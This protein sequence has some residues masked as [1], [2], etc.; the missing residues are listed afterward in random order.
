MKKAVIF[1]IALAITLT[2][3]AQTQQVSMY[4]VNDPDGWTNLRNEPG[5]D[6]DV[7]HRIPNKT[8]VVLDHKKPV[9]NNWIPVIY[10]QYYESFYIDQRRL[11]PIEEPYVS[12]LKEFS[13]FAYGPELVVNMISFNIPNLFATHH[14]AVDNPDCVS[15]I[16]DLKNDKVILEFDGMGCAWIIRSDTLSFY[17]FDYPFSGSYTAGSTYLNPILAIYKLYQKNGEYDFYTEIYPEPRTVSKEEAE[18]IVKNITDILDKNPSYFYTYPNFHEFCRQLFLAYC[19][20]VDKAKEIVENLKIITESY[21]D[22]YIDVRW[23][24]DAYDRTKL[25]P[26]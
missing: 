21:S 9:I 2:A 19:S 8:I 5:T 11:I 14:P 4:V 3:F 10:P 12:K 24:F 1:S 15:I 20:G 18:K 25:K 7:V 26:K 17:Y 13:F 16:K 6:G 23:W 22:D